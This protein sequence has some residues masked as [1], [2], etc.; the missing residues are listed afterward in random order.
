MRILH[1]ISG[2]MFGGGQRVVADLIEALPAMVGISCDLCLLKRNHPFFARFS[3]YVVPYRG[4]YRNPWT[5]ISAA[6]KLA[7]LIQELRPDIVHSHGF[8]AELIAALAC[9]KCRVPHVSHIHDTPVWT[10]SQRVKHMLRRTITRWICSRS[11]TWWIACSEAVRRH[12]HY[13]LR[14]PLDRIIT[15][16]NG[17]NFQVFSAAGHRQNDS[18]IARAERFLI[19]TAARLAA[20]KGIDL[21]V[22]AV[23]VLLRDGIPC[24]LRVAG[25]GP[26]YDRLMQLA[27]S[28]GAGG[29]V[30]FLGHM[31]DMVSFYRELDVFVLPSL[32]GEGLP[33][34]I[35]EA[36]AAGLPVVATTVAGIPE[37]LIDGVTGVTVP[38][39]D[40][41][42]IASALRELFKNP[43]RR[44]Q[45][46]SAGEA[47]VKRSFSLEA[48]AEKIKIAYLNVLA[49][50]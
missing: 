18:P 45:L 41:V 29:A 26:E 36:L 14:C 23:S 15:V 24:E 25:E 44:K 30:R 40:D 27:S 38:P 37:V 33:L 20:N 7:K 19:G 46:G 3:P 16:H 50:I 32:S 11:K 6:H 43:Q 12:A 47:I 28:L 49:H 2:G 39:G 1:V 31:A 4:N 42:A 21:L 10:S 34:V 22:R 8:D 9:H 5:A 48:M 35:L 13:F 17:I